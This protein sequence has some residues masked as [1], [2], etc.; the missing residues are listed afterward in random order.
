MEADSMEDQCS[1]EIV[2]LKCLRDVDFLGS[3]S[4]DPTTGKSLPIGKRKLWLALLWSGLGDAFSVA[5][6]E[7]NNQGMRGP[8]L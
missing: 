5:K 8:L 3:R 7:K 6:W 2:N 4:E 1:N